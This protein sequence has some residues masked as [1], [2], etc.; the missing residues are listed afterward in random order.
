M[1]YD[2]PHML[3]GAALLASLFILALAKGTGRHRILGRCFALL[4]LI[5]LAT[6]L[7]ALNRA[8]GYL[9]VL[10]PYVLVSGW[11][12]IYTKAKGPNWIDLVLLLCVVPATL[13]FWPAFIL[14]S[15]GEWFTPWL[16]YSSFG[17]LH[18]LAAYDGA[19]WFFPKRWYAALWP[20]EHIAKMIASLVFLLSAAVAR[21]LSFRPA[22]YQL[23]LL[24]SGLIA[25]A[26]FW[27][28]QARVPFTGNPAAPATGDAG[29]A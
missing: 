11:H 22:W 4:A 21:L 12:V 5:A 3:A 19:R 14:L 17:S 23:A 16:A 10:L 15:P 29:E 28:R 24:T 18:V 8:F 9:A 7:I 2:F 6:G 27:W 26:W 13:L 1:L 20:Y 25:I